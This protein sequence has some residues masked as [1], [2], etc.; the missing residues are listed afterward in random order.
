MI[1]SRFR[2]AERTAL[3]KH[4]GETP[5]P[6]GRIVVATQALEAGV[7]VTSAVM[8]TEIAPWSSLVQR[9]GRCN[10]YGECGSGGA[11]TFWIDLPDE[12]APPYD[13]NDLREAREKLAGLSACG[14]ADLAEIH[15]SAPE[16]GQVVRK[17]DLLDLFDTDPDLS[18]FDV[19]VSV[20]VRHTQ[21]TD[22]R[23]F[24]RSVEDGAAPPSDAPDPQRDELCPT[25]IGGAKD[26]VKRAGERAW[27]W[28]ALA[29]QWS[30]VGPGDLFP[31]LVL[32][33]DAVVGGYDATLGFDP[34]S[35]EAVAPVDSSST[36]DPPDDQGGDPFSHTQKALVSLAKHSARVREEATALADALG[37]STEDR[38]L[39]AEIA[40]HHDWG[41]AHEAFVALTA[42]ARA[43]RGVSDLLAK[44]PD[45]S[46][47]A[48]HPE[49]ARKYFRHELASALAY[50]EARGWRDDVSLAAYLIAAHHGKVH[51]AACSAEGGAGAGRQAV[52]P[53][54]S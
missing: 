11:E 27:R 51:A 29:K 34:S 41:K 12:A 23:L 4:L 50:L 10:R 43:E 26:L 13:E 33:I 20:Y 37:L 9:F 16:R 24:W 31:G 5:P 44:W 46:K 39:L 53:R 3:T 8:L 1:H 14:P 45:A 19:D 15:P 17:R 6:A 2:A 40:L 28:D 35:K 49:G 38:T 48:N 18:G 7:D 47:G 30:G 52:R 25:P 32:W 21:D 36:D 42:Q 54:R 22:V